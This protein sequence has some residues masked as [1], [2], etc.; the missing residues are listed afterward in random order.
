M[1]SN[2]G[3]SRETLI[4]RYFPQRQAEIARYAEL[5]AREAIL[6]GL[7]GPREGDRIWERHI[8]NS[9]PVISL[10]PQGASVIDIGS[11][12]GLPGIPL[13][14]ARPD[15]S[16]VLIEPLHRR[17]VFLEEA[18]LG[19]GITVLRGR[20]QDQ[21]IRAQ[22][23]VARAVTSLEKLKSWSWHLLDQGGVLLAIK[24]QNAADEAAGV[25]G[26][27]IHEIKLAGLELGRV[28]SLRKGA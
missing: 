19:L 10:I 27:Q 15:I 4:E 25:P 17:V 9:L 6:R 28:I 2:E 14:L 12:A 21:K 1:L 24:G 3:V 18:S 23:V 20:A 8:F 26:A 13:A 22:V 7:L 11:G 16:M 5:L